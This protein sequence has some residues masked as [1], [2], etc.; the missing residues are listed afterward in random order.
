M[1]A[2]RRG[3]LR[4]LALCEVIRLGIC[5]SHRRI[6]L[7]F[8]LTIHPKILGARESPYTQFEGLRDRGGRLFGELLLADAP[9][10]INRFGRVVDSLIGEICRGGKCAPAALARKSRS[11]PAAEFALPVTVGQGDVKFAN[12]SRHPSQ[13]QG[14]R[15]VIRDYRPLS[16]ASDGLS[17][18]FKL[19][20][21]SMP[22]VG[23]VAGHSPLPHCI[24]RGA[25]LGCSLLDVAE[26]AVP[27]IRGCRR[28]AKSPKPAAGWRGRTKTSLPRAIAI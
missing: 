2:F 10:S 26:L 23:Q 21:F 4:L 25:Q 14:S 24:R 5:V 13:P 18:A 16:L 6:P 8:G 15:N 9:A 19:R 17:E 22:R 20:R 1:E 12:S 28:L 7:R 3:R 11:G 27:L